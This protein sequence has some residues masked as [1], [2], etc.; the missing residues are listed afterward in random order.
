MGFS[1]IKKINE[2]IE[3]NWMEDHEL[4]GYIVVKRD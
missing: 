2:V 1:G 4:S 3:W